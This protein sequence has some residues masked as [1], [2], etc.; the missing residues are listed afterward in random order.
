MKIIDLV[1]PGKEVRFVYFHDQALWYETDCGF[2]FPIPVEDTRGAFFKAEDKAI[3]YMRWIRKQ[4]D[5]IEA[6]KT[7]S[8]VAEK[9]A[10]G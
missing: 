6:S 5:L 7:V 10:G 2:K 1:R 9:I 3:A 4:L 8:V